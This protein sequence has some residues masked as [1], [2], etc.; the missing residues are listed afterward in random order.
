MMGSESLEETSQGLRA[1]ATMDRKT[2]ASHW[3]KVFGSPAP[4]SA[5]VTL[6]RSALA[7]HYQIDREAETELNQLLRRLR[8][9]ATSGAPTSVLAPG[10]RLLREWQ[11]QT[12]HVTVI[13][14]GF[15]YGGK[16]YS[17]LSAIARY[18][19]GTAWSGPLFF[20]LKK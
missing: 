11:G 12:H 10:T 14:G 18:I 17:S 19:T 1:L 2:L 9:Q 5:Q 6:M 20:G 16:T 3:A 8:R 7:W 4:R 13:D 15:E